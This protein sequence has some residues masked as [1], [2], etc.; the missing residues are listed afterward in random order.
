M[1]PPSALIKESCRL[2]AGSCISPI[3]PFFTLIQASVT[4]AIGP[5]CYRQHRRFAMK[6]HVFFVGFIL[7]AAG[8]SGCARMLMP[9]ALM[10]IYTEG[11]GPIRESSVP[12]D[13]YVG[14]RGRW[15]EVMRLP[16]KSVVDVLTMEG[17]AHVGL[18][19]RADARAVRILING[20]DEQI[21][22]RRRAAS[23]RA[24]LPRPRSRRHRQTGGCCRSDE[25]RRS[26]RG[27]R[28]DWRPGMRTARCA[29]ASGGHRG[30]GRRTRFARRAAG[31]AHISRGGRRSA[32]GVEDPQLTLA[33]SWSL[34]AGS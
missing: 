8:T 15:D 14:V 33:G 28:R 7:T 21:A 22:A 23:R 2:P 31:T 13:P 11:K 26:L 19:T 1:G 24:L 17:T 4:T 30:H 27:C 6:K 20:I 16:A 9:L 10:A 5:T 34:E 3:Q 18:L 12:I 25:R 29:A 32:F